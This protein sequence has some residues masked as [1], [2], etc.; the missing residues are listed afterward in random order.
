[1]GQWGNDKRR[2]LKDKVR[3]TYKQHNLTIQFKYMT[4][5]WQAGLNELTQSMYI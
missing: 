2:C 5:V 4:T 3:T 1:M